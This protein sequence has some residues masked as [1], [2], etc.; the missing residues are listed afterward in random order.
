VAQP[1]PRSRRAGTRLT[2]TRLTGT[3]ALL[4]VLL[5]AG[6]GVASLSLLAV[7]EG[8]GWWFTMILVSFVVLACGAAARFVARHRAWG[9]LFAVAGAILLITLL[10]APGEAFLGVI[11]TI[12]S[13]AALAELQQEGLQ[14]IASQSVP[15]RADDG[16]LFLVAVGAAGLTVALDF[17][18]FS[19]R[20]PALTGIPLL[21]LALVPTFVV[22]DLGDPMVLVLTA[23]IYLAI[24]L[25]SAPRVPRRTALGVGSA[26]V[27]AA[28]IVPIFLPSVIPDRTPT[29]PGDRVATGLNPIITLGNDLRR[30]DPSLA[31]TYTTDS[32]TG[33]YLRLTALDDFTG[34]AWAPD[35]TA[36]L[37]DEGVV[38]IG[39]IP[40]LTP[41]VPVTTVTSEVTIANVLSRWLPVPYAPASVDGLTGEWGFDPDLLA[42]RS[43]DANAR[44]QEYTVS[45]VQVAPSVDQLLAAGTTVDAELE[46]YLGLPDDLPAIVAETAAEVVGAAPTNYEKALALQDYFRSGDFTYSEEA[47][48]ENDYDGSGASVLQ[49]FLD[50]KAGYCVHFS[51]AMAAMARSLD[52]PSRIAVGFTPGEPTTGA[53]G[54]VTEYR[55]STDNFH[56]WPELWFAGIGWVRF[57]PTPSR[58]ETPA[59]AP[60]TVDDPATP[61]VDESVP[62]PPTTSAP[63]PAPTSS[64]TGAPSLPPEETDT[65]TA[66]S[67]DAA[68]TAIPW[69]TIAGVLAALLLLTPALMRMARRRTRLMAVEDGSAAQA[70]TE[71]RDTALDLGLSPA[72]TLTPR[73]ATAELAHLLDDD[74][75]AALARLRDALEQESFAGRPGEPVLADLRT[76]LWSLRR[77]AG[78]WRTVLAAVAP[79][80]LL[81]GVMVRA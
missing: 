79:R 72:D 1:E 22:T 18:A 39:P 75:A 17:A 81:A 9:S 38:E 14:S 54:A 30:A 47:P 74:G 77:S 44:G 13:I 52:I 70:W 60:S 37:S 64:S 12:E 62:P 48:V 21:V 34:V 69:G 3:D 53:D 45:S 43:R 78:L 36:E 56:A 28:L 5:L 15:A 25:L 7:L 31:L 63:T 61:E 8:F 46:R 16:I 27:V 76:V 80:S 42:V 35:E 19:V 51:S 29:G 33:L 26:A 58:G 10:F 50:A 67:G 32:T 66:Q 65:P 73:Q 59:F 41:E 55:V 71:L 20:M 68:A 40:G 24:L 57:E 11:P 2:G 4:A 6:V 23:V 49:A